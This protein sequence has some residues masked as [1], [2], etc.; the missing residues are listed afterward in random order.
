MF[1]HDCGQIYLK[2]EKMCHCRIFINR[3][4]ELN[5]LFFSLL[6]YTVYRHQIKF[7]HP[8]LL[9]PITSLIII[10]DSILFTTV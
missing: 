3:S 2:S 8:M 4:L 10:I 6:L 1:N 5:S 9:A 7:G